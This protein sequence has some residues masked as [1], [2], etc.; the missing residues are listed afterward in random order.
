MYL[1]IRLF[2][3]NFRRLFKNSSRE[4]SEYNDALLYS[5]ICYPHL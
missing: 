2:N 3:H 5:D 4:Y 1:R